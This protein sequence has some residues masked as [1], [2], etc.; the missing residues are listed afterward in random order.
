MALDRTVLLD[1]AATHATLENSGT[2][3]ADSRVSIDWSDSG[4]DSVVTS[5]LNFTGTA[6]GSVDA[7]GFY[8]AATGGT[9]A[10]S[11]SLDAGSDGA[12]NAEGKFNITS[13]KVS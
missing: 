3:V 2:E 10:G 13:L 9:Y 6:N 1:S 7:V 11:I 8:D 12:F 4:G 5:T